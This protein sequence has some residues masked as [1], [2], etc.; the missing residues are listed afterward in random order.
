MLDPNINYDDT[1]TKMTS[2]DEIGLNLHMT[3][4]NDEEIKTTENDKN[5]TSNDRGL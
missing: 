2:T 1:E 3:Y 5:D 4:M